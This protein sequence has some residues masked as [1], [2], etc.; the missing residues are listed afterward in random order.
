MA[1]HARRTVGSRSDD[2][3]AEAEA[4]ASPLPEELAVLTPADWN[5]NN[6]VLQPAVR[7]LQGASADLQAARQAAR[8]IVAGLKA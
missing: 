7:A 3:Y 6:R 5:A 2:I 1:S 4:A 8:E